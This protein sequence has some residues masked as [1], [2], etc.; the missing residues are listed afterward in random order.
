MYVAWLLSSLILSHLHSSTLYSLLTLPPYNEVVETVEQFMRAAARDTV[1]VIS[2]DDGSINSAVSRAQPKSSVF[3]TIKEH[4][5]RNKVQLYHDVSEIVPIL[6]SNPMNI[7]VS[8]EIKLQALQ[9]FASKQLY[10]RAESISQL[11]L[12]WAFRKGSTLVK[13]FNKR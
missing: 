9:M 10:I 3:Y 5:R 7:L 2:K 1:R 11:Y 6:E 13:I 4:I 12:S 8:Y